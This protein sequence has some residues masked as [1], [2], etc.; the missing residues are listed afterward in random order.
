MKT[1]RPK[2]YAHPAIFALLVLPF[3]AAVGEL[4]VA[5]P[6]WFERGGVS[7]AAIAGMMAVAGQ[8]LTLKLFWVPLIDLGNVR[9]HWYLWSCVLTAGAMVAIGFVPD[10]AHHLALI[11][12]LLCVAQVGA[13]TLSAAL[14]A[15]MAVT[16]LEEDK[17]RAGGYYAAGNVGGTTALGGLAIWIAAH[18]S[19]RMASFAMAAVVM[20]TSLGVWSMT[21]HAQEKVQE[22]KHWLATVKENLL[23]ILRDL[24][25]TVR[26]R[27]GF[28]GM[29]IC[30]APVGCGALQNGLFSG[31][32]AAYQMTDDQLF[33]L[34]TVWS[35]IVCIGGSL[36]G[37][38]IADRMNRRLA[39]ALSGGITALTA[40]AMAMGPL[41][42]FTYYWGTLAYNFAVGISY[43]AFYGMVLEMVSHGAAVTTKYTLF[44]A[45]SNQAISYVTYLD[46]KH[47]GLG[48]LGEQRGTIVFDGLFTFV[49]IA[50]L[51]FMVTIARRTRE[52]IPAIAPG[53]GAS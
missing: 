38:Y 32:S 45:F 46:A 53:G 17:G 50:L 30:L 4:Q 20:L 13:A 52:P 23:Q 36:V 33:W 49:G 14:D 16:T 19:V 26:S 24:W 35:T 5:F 2:G 44:V 10:P 48:F 31:M 18:S 7:L 51:I 41:T 28:T 25:V 42:P 15:L 8:P 21:E 43:A 39:Y 47:F 37:G 11:T 34:N 29:V 9:K 6:R 22:V 40:F 1:P 12:A 27:E 3:G